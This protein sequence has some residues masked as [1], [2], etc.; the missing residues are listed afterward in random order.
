MRFVSRLTRVA[1]GPL[2]YK[3]GEK[4][5]RQNRESHLTSPLISGG[6]LH[7]YINLSHLAS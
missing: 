2:L 7:P 3:D 5:F 4:L 1:I 6:S